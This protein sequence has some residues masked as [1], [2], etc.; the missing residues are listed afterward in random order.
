MVV[1][2]KHTLRIIPLSVVMGFFLE[3]ELELLENL[4]IPW[5]L[6]SSPLDLFFVVLV[7][8]TEAVGIDNRLAK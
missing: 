3:L 7:G 4:L 6:T 2:V 1:L 5:L 8:V